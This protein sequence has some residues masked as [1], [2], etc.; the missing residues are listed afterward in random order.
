MPNE[1]K[2]IITI[3]LP[4]NVRK[5]ASGVFEARFRKF[6]LNISV[7]SKDYSELKPKL[8][9]KLVNTILPSQNK[10]IEEDPRNLSF[11]AVALR[12]LELKKPTI[13]SNT[14]NFY[15]QLFEANIF[16][17]LGERNIDTIR[18]S[19]IQ[20]MI[21]NYILQDKYRTALK[22]YQSLKAVFDFAVGEELLNR[23][24]MRMIRPPKYEEVK[25]VALTVAE[26]QEFLKLLNSSKCQKSIKDALIIL[27]YTGIRR[28]ELASIK[29]DNDFISV[30]NSKTRKGFNERRRLIPITPMLR[31]WLDGIDLAAACSIRPNALT[32]AFKRLMPAHHL[33]ELRH[34]FITRCQECGIAREV[35]SVWAGHSADNSMTSNT[36]THFSREFL[37]EQGEKVIY[38]I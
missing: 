1:L 27:L 16:A 20:S 7:S 19:D 13:K 18:Q 9:Q 33:H 23:S 25:G 21:N 34:T 29:I 4:F 11:K 24:P 12:W 26:E 38:N 8:M 2:K 5:K 36:Y 14:Y 3:D 17:N 15:V 28:S 35:V 31:R 32:Q 22:I 37:K 10:L 6:G 30:L